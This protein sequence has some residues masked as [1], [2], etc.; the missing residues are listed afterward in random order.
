MANGKRLSE[1][2]RAQLSCTLCATANEGRMANSRRR[3]LLRPSTDPLPHALLLFALRGMH[4][5]R[6]TVA[7]R[8]S[9]DTGQGVATNTP[10]PSPAG[11]GAPF[12][13]AGVG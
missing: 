6:L 13:D 3:P 11:P 2:T 12:Q 10:G 1:G 7:A 4:K 8:R 9:G 5:K